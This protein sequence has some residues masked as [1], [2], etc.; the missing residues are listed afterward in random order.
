M[1]NG[2]IRGGYKEKNEI[3]QEAILKLALEGV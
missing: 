3:S 2:K 1:S